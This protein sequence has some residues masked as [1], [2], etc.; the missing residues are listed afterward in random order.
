MLQIMVEASYRKSLIP[1][2][3]IIIPKC[4][5]C[6][7]QQFYKILH[8]IFSQLIEFRKRNNTGQTYTDYVTIKG[9]NIDRLVYRALTTVQYN[10][11]SYLLI[12]ESYLNIFNKEYLMVIM[13]N[14]SDTQNIPVD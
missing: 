14:M 5:R 1:T 9:M 6:R 4:Q 3:N 12:D 7:T 2:E 10:F 8:N 13:N 11:S